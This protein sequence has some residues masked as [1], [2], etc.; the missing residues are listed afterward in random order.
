MTGP[1][2]ITGPVDTTSEAKPFGQGSFYPVPADL[3]GLDS[4]ASLGILKPIFLRIHVEEE[5]SLGFAGLTRHEPHLL[6]STIQGHDELPQKVHTQ[7]TFH[8]GRVWEQ[9]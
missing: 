5:V 7:Q 9:L 8:R 6:G 4:F 2:Y 1:K 3:Q